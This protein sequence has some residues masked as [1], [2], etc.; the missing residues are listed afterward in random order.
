MDAQIK[1]RREVCA[2][3]MGQSTSD[4]VVMDAP[5]N[6]RREECV[7]VTEHTESP[8][9]NLQLLH[10]A[11]GQNLRKTTVTRPYQRNSGS[12]SNLGS[13]PQEVVLPL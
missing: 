10:H 6:Q 5:I 7:E 2:S 3:N 4:A 11:L 12:S 8:T 13:F 9:M 1:L